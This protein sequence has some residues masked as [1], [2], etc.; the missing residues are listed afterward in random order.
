VSGDISFDYTN[1]RGEQ[2]R[3]TVTPV[4]HRWGTSQ[5]HPELQ[6]LMLA[7]DHDKGQPREFAVKDMTNIEVHPF[8]V[9]MRSEGFRSP[10]RD[11]ITRIDIV[12]QNHLSYSQACG[13][14]SNLRD[15]L[16]AMAFCEEVNRRDAHHALPTR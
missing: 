9:L 2:S 16:S 3:R 7:L 13:P 12:A 11:L 14:I 4:T 1:Y 8:P 5:W 10:L 15:H 6:W